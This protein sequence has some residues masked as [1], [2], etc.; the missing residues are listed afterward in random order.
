MCVSIIKESLH[1]NSYSILKVLQ[2][3]KWWQVFYC[4]RADQ[5]YLNLKQAITI[6]S[7]LWVFKRP[8]TDYSSFLLCET[9][10]PIANSKQILS[11]QW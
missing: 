5:V 11:L 7:Y 1:E 9:K 4:I 2:E 10:L 3:H 8:T 6:R